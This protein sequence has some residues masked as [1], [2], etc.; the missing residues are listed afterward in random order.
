MQ[1][2]HYIFYFLEYRT[3][4]KVQNRSNAEWYTLP[5]RS[6]LPMYG[7]VVLYNSLT[8]MQSVAPCIVQTSFA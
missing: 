3:L 5:S 7:F 6:F 4:D 1:F 8:C 2:A